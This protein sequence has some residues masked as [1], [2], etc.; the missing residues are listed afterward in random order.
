L[1]IAEHVKAEAESQNSRDYDYDSD[2][3]TPV[4][5]EGGGKDASSEPG[6][7]QPVQ[8]TDAGSPSGPK[9]EQD[10]PAKRERKRN[11]PLRRES[12][13]NKDAKKAERSR[14]E[15]AWRLK[16][17]GNPKGYLSYTTKIYLVCIVYLPM[18]EC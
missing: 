14:W 16:S 5:V 6:K 4:P 3:G 15:S 1:N 12:K 7:K 10:M 13:K 18:T 2:S 8:Q 17:D 11:R 9:P